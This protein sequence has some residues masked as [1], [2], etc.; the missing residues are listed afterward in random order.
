MGYQAQEFDGESGELVSADDD[1]SDDEDF[2]EEA[3]DFDGD[4]DF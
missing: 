3:D 4:E 2:E 1:F